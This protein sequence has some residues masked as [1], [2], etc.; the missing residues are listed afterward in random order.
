MDEI[1]RIAVECVGRAV[2]FGSLAIGCVMVGFSF[3]PVSAF[4]SGAI[5][6]LLMAVV[7]MWKAKAAASK[8]PKHTEVWLYLDEKSRPADGHA[9]FV[10]G[11]VMREVYGR[12]AQITLGV[13]IGFFALSLV[14]ML[15]GLE[16]Y[17]PP[18]QTG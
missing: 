15:F 2:M 11:T 17:E 5:L 6:T 13:A 3:A 9:Q 12:F 4:R 18:S 7:L 10:L 8:N 14:L 16:P 1:R